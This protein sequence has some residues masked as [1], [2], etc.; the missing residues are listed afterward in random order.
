ME[1]F[2]DFPREV[3]YRQWRNEERGGS[4]AGTTGIGYRFER[5]G[6]DHRQQNETG[7][8]GGR[9]HVVSEIPLIGGSIR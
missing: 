3:G 9:V 4:A 6:I 2:R 8:A 1:T 5:D 7:V